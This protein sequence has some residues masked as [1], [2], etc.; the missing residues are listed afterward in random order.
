MLSR[1]RGTPGASLKASASKLPSTEGLDFGP[2]P[3]FHEKFPNVGTPFIFDEQDWLTLGDGDGY[4]EYFPRK[5]R[6]KN[7]VKWG[8][9]K[10][11]TTELQFFNKY[12]DPK[13]VPN[14]V[15]VYVGS[16][17]GTHIKVLAD[18]FPAF[19]FHLY[20]PRD[21]FDKELRKNSKIKLHVQFFEDK[22]AKKY[23]KRDDVFFISDIRSSNYNKNQF[24]SEEVERENEDL[25]LQ[26][27]ALQKKWYDI[28]QPV[29]AHLKFRLPYTYGWQKTMDD[30]MH[31]EYLDGDIYRQAWAPQTST[32][33]RL[34]P[35][36]GEPLRKW[37]SALYEKMCFYHN[38]VIRE[39]AVFVNPLNGL[40]S[41]IDIESGLI[42]DYDSTVFVA[43]V[44]DYLKKFTLKGVPHIDMDPEVV[45]NLS[46][47]IIEDIGKDDVDIVSIRAGAK[48]KLSPSE[49]AKLQKKIGEDDDDE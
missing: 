14:P 5:G 25:V 48:G 38:N 19:E 27:L 44:K 37:N 30:R 23:A 6:V 1:I 2:T 29:R 21:V 24:P 18:M 40:N 7:S 22:D 3:A 20:D 8:Q 36:P 41:D 34:V 28:I 43:T 11:F 33:T 32:E 4:Q 45:L 49:Q 39:H 13:A 9:L 26:D 31:F 15:C 35:T 17:P 10:L 16:A 42:Q 47:H 46:K 12:W